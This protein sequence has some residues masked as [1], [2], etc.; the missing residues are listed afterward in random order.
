MVHK[1]FTIHDFE[2][3]LSIDNI[4][5]IIN[6]YLLLLTIQVASIKTLFWEFI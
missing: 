4:E 2:K 3:R 5:L 6:Q 1:S